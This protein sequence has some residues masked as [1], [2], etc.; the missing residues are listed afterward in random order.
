MTELRG[1]GRLAWKLLEPLHAITYFSPEPVTAF[2]EA[3]YKGYWMGYFAT[4]AAPL[5]PI[6]PEITHALFY[7]FTYERVAKALP[8]A[9]SYAPPEAALEARLS[10]SVAALRRQLGELGD[11]GRNP[12]LVRAAELAARAAQSAP[13]IGRPL[14]AANRALPM[15]EEPLA[16]L[17]QAATVLREHRGDGHVAALLTAGIA[18]RE[19]HIVQVLDTGMPR[20]LLTL[21]RD[22]GD[23][24]WAQ[25]VA[26]L[27]EKGL[28]STDGGELA[29]SGEG[30]RRK[31][32]VEE[33]TD[34]LAAEAYAALSAEE[35]DELARLL[36]PLTQAVARA[37]DL[38]PHLPMGLAL[39]KD[40]AEK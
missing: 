29:L 40:I 18:G 30:A 31:A 13:I 3:G 32:W 7:N 25:Q 11:P 34:E 12:G 28:V 21:A 39:D 20:D 19:C 35:R 38:P 6:G 16:R 8:E 15:P 17:W 24:E 36:R 1:F 9:W 14:A 33:R 27:R 26:S 10:G 4:R 2:A 37:G 23:D 22:F 5:G